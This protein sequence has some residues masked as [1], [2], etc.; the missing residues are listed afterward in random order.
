M[1][2]VFKFKKLDNLVKTKIKEVS[3]DKV[4]IY[5]PYPLEGGGGEIQRDFRNIVAK[6]FPNYDLQLFSTANSKQGIRLY[7][8]RLL[9]VINNRR[10]LTDCNI[11]IIQ[12]IFD[13]GAIF[14]G[15]YAH[16]N[17]IPYIVVPRG[18]YIPTK[19]FFFITRHFFIKWVSWLLLGRKLIKNAIAVVVTSEYEKKRLQKV[20]ARDDHINIIPDPTFKYILDENSIKSVSREDIM[21]LSKKPFALWLGRIAREKGLDLLLD[22]WPSVL[23]R[24]PSAVLVFAGSI[25]HEDVYQK[26]LTK[27]KTLNLDKSVLFLDWVSGDEKKYL[28]FKARCLLLPS[29]YESF[30][31][32]VVE[33]LS[34][35]TPIIVSRGTP[36]QQIDNSAGYCLPRDV[37]LWSDAITNYMTLPKKQMISEEVIYNLMMPYKMTVIYEQWKKLFAKTIWIVKEI[38]CKDHQFFNVNKRI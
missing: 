30:G 32:V 25:T 1:G 26:L 28:L 36:W 19:D 14:I 9:K 7:I 24:C 37:S 5:N 20:F 15:L 27:I 6:C 18:D 10:E 33:A 35:R 12:G 38:R 13:P 31:I 4:F 3:S 2:Y 11:I 22:C 17:K 29:H 16:I 21:I 34:S 23:K 8:H